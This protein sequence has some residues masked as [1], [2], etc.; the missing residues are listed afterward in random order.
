VG[1]RDIF[2]VTD[3]SFFRLITCPMTAV[4]FRRCWSP[5]RSRTDWVLL[6]DWTEQRWLQSIV[7]D[8]LRPS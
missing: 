3:F 6:D 7:A 4:A 5:L 1:L 2:D 8:A